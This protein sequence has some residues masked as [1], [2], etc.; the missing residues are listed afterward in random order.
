MLKCV[1]STSKILLNP[2]NPQNPNSTKIPPQYLDTEGVSFMLA[3]INAY[4]EDLGATG[5]QDTPL[6]HLV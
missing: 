3:H 2:L 1:L 6:R 5:S 4:F